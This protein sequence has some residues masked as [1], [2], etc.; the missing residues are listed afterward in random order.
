MS[1]SPERRRYIR[2]VDK[3]RTKRPDD[4]IPAGGKA[5]RGTRLAM[6]VA[7]W[8][9]RRLSRKK[10]E[11]YSSLHSGP[12]LAWLQTSDSLVSGSRLRLP[13]V[14]LCCDASAG[15]RCLPP[16][17]VLPRRIIQIDCTQVTSQTREHVRRGG[18]RT[19]QGG[20]ISRPSFAKPGVRNSDRWPLG[21]P[22]TAEPAIRNHENPI[23]VIDWP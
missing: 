6:R 19:W 8:S 21:P 23:F 16:H 3:N 1:G 9:R 15:P 12:E 11:D 4:G 20:I 22:S 5:S 17:Q 14:I 10:K 13:C 7:G 2:G 18:T